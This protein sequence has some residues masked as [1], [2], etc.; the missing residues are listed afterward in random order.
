LKVQR[1]EEQATVT[2]PRPDV[3]DHDGTSPAG[4][5]AWVLG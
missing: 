3:I 4:G 1:I 2:L 5:A